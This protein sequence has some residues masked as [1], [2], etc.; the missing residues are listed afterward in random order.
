V[1]APKTFKKLALF[2]DIHFGRRSNSRV[3]NQDCLDFVTWFCEQV[4]ASGD[5][6]HICFLGDW[7]ESRSAINIETLD[8]SYAALKMVDDLGLPI[9]FM[10]GNHDLHRRTTRDVHSVRIFNELKNVMVV[11]DVHVEDGMLFAPYLFE[12]EYSKLVQHNNLWAWLGHFEFKNFILTGNSRV[13]DHGPD[14][15]LFTGPKQIM[16]GHFHKRQSQDNVVYLGNVFPMDFGDAA[17]YERGM[18]TYYVEENKLTFTNWSSC[19]KYYKTKLSQVLEGKWAPLAKMKVKCV[20][21]GELGYQDAQDLR[22]AM[23]IAHD[24]RDF[25]LEE[26]RAAKQGMVEG[27]NV[28][29]TESMLDF[30]TIDDLVISQLE[31]CKGDK[32]LTVEADLLVEIYKGLKIEAET[33]AEEM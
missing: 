29:V 23:I 2:T 27:E 13:M 22:E 1:N 10:V 14:H 5:Y 18:A 31:A 30:T 33:E 16:S 20:I 6:S 24:L 11:Q 28:K 32:K 15:K 9:Y 3:H 17:D 7:F 8:Y 4:K 25:I 12:D 26:D 21:D 19:P